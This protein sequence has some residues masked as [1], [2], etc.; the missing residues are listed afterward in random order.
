MIRVNVVK[1]EEGTIYFDVCRDVRLCFTSIIYPHKNDMVKVRSWAD[2]D[3]M[4]A[5]EM[6]DLWGELKKP[7]ISPPAVMEQIRADVIELL[8]DSDR[9]DL[10]A[11]C[12]DNVPSTEGKKRL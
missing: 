11:V 2:F 10:V 1:Y 9:V 12:L 7:Y 4:A 8:Y 5:A 3:D 6:R